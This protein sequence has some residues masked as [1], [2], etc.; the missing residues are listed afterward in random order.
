[1]RLL[2]PEIGSPQSWLF[3][4]VKG[5]NKYTNG[6][7]PFVSGLKNINDSTL[8]IELM[9]PFAPFIQYLAMPS[10]S[11]INIKHEATIK[12]IP[13]GSGPWIMKNWERDGFIS[14]ERNEH[15]WGVLP[16]SKKLSFRILSESMARM[17]EFEAGNLDIVKIPD[18]ELTRW[19]KKANWTG[20]VV[21]KDELSIWYIGMNY[22]RPPFNDRRVRLAMNLAL[23]RQ[24]IISLLLSGSGTLAEGPVPPQLMSAIQNNPFPFN[25]EKAIRLLESAGYKNGLKTKLWVA[26]GSEMFHVLEAFQSY[27]EAVGITVEIVNSDW[28]VFKTAVR[29]GTV[30]L[31]YLDWYA[32]YPDAENF[33]YPLFH[34]RESMTKRSRYSNPEVDKNIEMIQRLTPGEKRSILIEETHMMIKNDAP[35]VFLWHGKTHTAVQPWIKGYAPKLIFNAERYLT[36]HQ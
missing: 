20:Q 15:Y 24:K 33:L 23:D 11:I 5:A 19:K 30:D 28:N 32:D 12:E 7:A 25:P 6:N 27:W 26:G 21:G 35:W 8:V 36:I 2:S 17:A 4:K 3:N 22:I 1:M 10:A 14:Y 29:Q 9:E 13:S 34:S 16:K 31:Y 18:I